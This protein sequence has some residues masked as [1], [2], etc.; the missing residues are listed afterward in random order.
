LRNQTLYIGTDRESRGIEGC[1]SKHQQRA[2]NNDRPP[3]V[4]A[5]IDNSND[6]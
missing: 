5:E 2:R 6:C 1:G 3:I 4:S